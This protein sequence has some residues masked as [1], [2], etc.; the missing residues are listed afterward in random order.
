MSFFSNLEMTRILVS[1][2]KAFYSFLGQRI[3]LPNKCSKN[4]NVSVVDSFPIYR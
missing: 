1:N 4:A 3:I 2:E